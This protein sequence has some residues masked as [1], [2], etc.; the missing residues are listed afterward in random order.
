MIEGIRMNS[1]M[2][3]MKGFAFGVGVGPG[4][5]ELMTLKAVRILQEADIIACPGK[6]PEDSTAFKIAVKSVPCIAHKELISIS[7]PMTYDRS[8]QDMEHLESSRRIMKCLDEGKNVAF[9][10]LGDPTIYSSFSYYQKILEREGYS[11]EIISGV[12]SFCAVA[13]KLNIPLIE[14]NEQMHVIPAAHQD[15]LGERFPGTCIYMKSGKKL[16]ELKGHLGQGET[17]TVENCGLEGE[18]VTFGIPDQSDYYTTVI[19]K[20]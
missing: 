14:W 18:K 2:N 20:E 7:V 9:L 19:V 5:P 11:T 17:Y 16:K 3:R 1:G 6:V 13:A 15:N 4:D 10:V 12:P 8:Q